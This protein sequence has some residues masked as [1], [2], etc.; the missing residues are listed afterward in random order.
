M[1]DADRFKLLHGPYRTPRC[2]LGKKLFCEMRGWVTVTRISDAPIPWPMMSKQGGKPSL[3]LCGDL[4]KA[5][6]RESGIAV[7]HWFGVSP[8]TVTK[9]RKALD[10]PQVNAGTARLYREYQPEKIPPEVLQL[11]HERANA[12]EANAKKAEA[13][14]G[15]PLPAIVLEKA[16]RANLGRPLSDEHRRKMS[17]AHRRRGTVPPAMSGRLWTPEEEALLGTMPDEE[18][19]R[20]TDRSLGAVRSHRALLNIDGFHRRRERPSPKKREPRARLPGTDSQAP[21]RAEVDARPAAGDRT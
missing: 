10:V 13:K 6:R 20:R 17:E 16:R 21:T 5:V 4:V 11:A 8:Q 19:A 1:L 3:V 14:R 9:L 15:K 18:V 7:A 12:P 2:R